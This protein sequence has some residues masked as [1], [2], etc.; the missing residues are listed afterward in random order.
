MLKKGIMRL[1][2]YCVIIMGD[3]KDVFLEIEKV[4]DDKPNVLDAKGIVIA[5]FSSTLIIN[6]FCF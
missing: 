3:T 2:N 5:T 1:R 4:S 6:E